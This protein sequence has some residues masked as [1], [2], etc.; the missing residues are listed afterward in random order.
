MNNNDRPPEGASV[1]YLM[2]GLFV[3]ALVS[4][5]AWIFG[6]G[7]QTGHRL[8][9]TFALGFLGF[10]AGFFLSIVIATWNQ[11]RFRR[12]SVMRHYSRR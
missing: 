10:Y 7:H 12:Q 4:L 8:G 9:M 5:S 3:A 1:V 6:A 2:C 11:W